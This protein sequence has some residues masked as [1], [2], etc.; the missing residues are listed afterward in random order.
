MSLGLWWCLRQGTRLPALSCASESQHCITHAIDFSSCVYSHR[1]GGMDLD[2]IS[3][4]TCQCMAL[5]YTGIL[6]IINHLTY[7]VTNLYCREEGDCPELAHMF[8]D[9]VMCKGQVPDNNNSNHGN[10]F[11]SQF[12]VPVCTMHSFNNPLWMALYHGQMVRPN[13][14]T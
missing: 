7:M 11:T 4:S 5:G 13:I 9:S 8:Y 1:P 6:V 2:W 14:C 3:R 10:E 12:K